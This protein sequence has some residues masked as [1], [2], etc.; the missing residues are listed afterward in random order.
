MPR[1]EGML[2]EFKTIPVDIPGDKVMLQYKRGEYTGKLMNDM[3]VGGAPNERFLARVIAS[4][5]LTY[6][7]PADPKKP[8]G[9]KEEKPYPITEEAIAA[10]P[11]SFIIACVQAIEMDQLPNPRPRGE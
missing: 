1:V 7:I 3:R 4:W 2:A 9:E 11:N 10:L 6:L 8:N 5:D